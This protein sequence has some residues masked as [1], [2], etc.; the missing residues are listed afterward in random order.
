MEYKIFWVQGQ[1]YFQFFL[2]LIFTIIT[3]KKYNL[4]HIKIVD[5]FRVQSLKNNIHMYG[6]AIEWPPYQYFCNRSTVIYFFLI[7]DNSRKKYPANF[8]I[9]RFNSYIACFTVFVQSM[10]CLVSNFVLFLEIRSNDNDYN[11]V[12]AT[13]LFTC[14]ICFSFTNSVDRFR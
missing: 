6:K 5:E 1:W 13:D 2:E 10:F 12:S 8:R 4:N 3:I 9:S 14:Y 7:S 11:Q